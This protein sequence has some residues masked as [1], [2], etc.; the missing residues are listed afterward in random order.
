MF[1]DGFLKF[2]PV[3]PTYPGTHP[4]PALLQPRYFVIPQPSAGQKP[5][6]AKRTRETGSLAN[7]PS[8]TESITCQSDNGERQANIKILN[9]T[10]IRPKNSGIQARVTPDPPIFGGAC[11][12]L[13]RPLPLLAVTPQISVITSSYKEHDCN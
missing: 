13:H 5:T 9:D 2:D 10:K 12:V 11:S 4:H 1:A 8:L 6:P 7:S 3:T